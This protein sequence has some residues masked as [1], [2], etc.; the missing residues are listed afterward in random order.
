[1]SSSAAE[2]FQ[3]LQCE[4]CGAQIDIAVGVRTGSCPYCAAPAVVERPASE[5]REDPSFVIGF[6]VAK[7]RALET[8]R[9]WVRSTWFTPSAFRK[10]N[11]EDVRGIYLPSYLYTSAAHV[12]YSAS[13]GEN[14]TVVE[15]Y[16]TTDSKGNTVTRTRT[17]V[18]T[19]WRSLSGNWAAYLDDVVVTASRG[20]PNAELDAVE[21]FDLRA[22]RRYTPK[23]VSGW[24]AEEPS[25]HASECAVTART[26]AMGQL[27]R[28][29]AAHMPGDSHRG[30]EF[31]SQFVHEDLELLLLPVWIFAVR[32][33]AEKPPVRLV[34]NG[35]TGKITGKPPRSWLKIVLV[36]LFVVVAIGAAYGI[37]SLR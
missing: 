12:S 23:V 31:K 3:H 21:P 13:I 19:E 7:D 9:K 34:I 22:L 14:Y 8:A 25:L 11:L 29:L 1:M 5:K 33:H 16:T 36:V 2:Q 18:K 37:A 35:Q 10:A 27:Q 30:L 32:Y 15:T 24:V 28:R 6:V 26:E 20:L 17:K 4:G